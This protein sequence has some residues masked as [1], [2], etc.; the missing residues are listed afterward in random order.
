VIVLKVLV[1]GSI[2][3]GISNPFT[4]M[5]KWWLEYGSRLGEEVLGYCYEEGIASLRLLTPMLVF[6][7]L[8]Q[9]IQFLIHGYLSEWKHPLG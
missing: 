6:G 4:L 3:R 8:N 1:K 2:I 9:R 5:V 7:E